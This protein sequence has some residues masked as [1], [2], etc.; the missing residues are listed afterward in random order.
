MSK[1]KQ[2]IKLHCQGTGKRSIGE[3]L[4]ISK[5]TAKAYIEIFRS[6]KI[7]WDELS[8]MSDHEVDRLFHP[9]KQLINLRN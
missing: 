8:K 2:I 9:E 1:L 3:T 4:G 6:L 7:T 5:N